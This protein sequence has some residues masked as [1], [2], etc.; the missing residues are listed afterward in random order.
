MIENWYIFRFF[1]CLWDIFRLAALLGR[2][3]KKIFL[4]D[5]KFS[6]LSTL[7]WNYARSTTLKMNV[8]VERQG[9]WGGH[10]HKNKS[11]RKPVQVDSVAF[12]ALFLLADAATLVTCFSCKYC[13]YIMKNKNVKSQAF[14]WQENIAN[15]LLASSQQNYA[16]TCIRV[17]VY[18]DSC[19]S[20]LTGSCNY[21]QMTVVWMMYFLTLGYPERTGPNVEFLSLD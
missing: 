21:K 10:F 12:S 7:F 13:F 18:S 5:F 3:H 1:L 20:G 8:P 14:P 17:F 4:N 19:G 6:T 15:S 16:Y 9:G 11:R 2:K